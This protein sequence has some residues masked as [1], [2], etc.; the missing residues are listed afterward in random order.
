VY[1]QDRINDEIQDLRNRNRAGNNAVKT[2]P[3]PRFQV[4]GQRQEEARKRPFFLKT[5]FPT[6]LET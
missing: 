6:F 3:G 4:S 1:L 5:A 2:V